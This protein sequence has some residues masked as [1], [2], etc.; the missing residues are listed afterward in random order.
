M[1]V[2]LFFKYMLFITIYSVQVK[3]RRSTRSVLIT[4]GVTFSW[5]VSVHTS[6]TR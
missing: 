5:C 6:T 2:I 4:W 1:C 3:L